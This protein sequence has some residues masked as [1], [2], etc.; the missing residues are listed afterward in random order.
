[1]CGLIVGI[2]LLKPGNGST[3]DPL[4]FI[5]ECKDINVYFN[6]FGKDCPDFWTMVLLAAVLIQSKPWKRQSN[7]QFSWCESLWR[8]VGLGY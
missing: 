5:L 3:R 7:L 6:V 2:W 4:K 8:C 1:M